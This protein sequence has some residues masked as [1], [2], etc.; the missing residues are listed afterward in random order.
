MEARIR[1]FRHLWLVFALSTVAS[2]ANE[3]IP[4]TVSD[5]VRAA[6]ERA[7]T[8]LDG[9]DK[10]LALALYEGSLYPNGIKVGIDERTLD[11]E[12]QFRAVMLAFGTWN[13]ELGGD[14]PIVYVSD[15]KEAEVVISFVDAIPDKGEDALGIIRLQKNFRWSKTSHEVI[16]KGT[17]SIVKSAPGGKLTP[18]E[19]R[20]VALHELGH[21]LGL[22]DQESVGWIMGPMERGKPLSRPADSEVEDVKSLRRLLRAKIDGAR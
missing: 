8:A 18:A 22:G 19:V 12:G 10:Q 17:I 16:Y 11:S 6:V 14:S 9:G 15:P 21:L 7:G 4:R 5:D 2:A 20:D 13:D 3:A 1:T